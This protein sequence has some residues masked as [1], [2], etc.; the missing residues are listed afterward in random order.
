MHGRSAHARGMAGLRGR[1]VPDLE[2]GTRN[3]TEDG[4]G[5]RRGAIFGGMGGGSGGTHTHTHNHPCS[6]TVLEHAES[7]LDCREHSL[8]S[9]LWVER[10]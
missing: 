1:A 10:S 9:P 5:R 8:P 6:C 3:G 7:K 2:H 4:V